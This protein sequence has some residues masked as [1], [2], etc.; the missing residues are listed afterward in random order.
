[1]ASESQAVD[2]EVLL[3]AVLDQ[4]D[5]DTDEAAAIAVALGAHIGDQAR[6]AAAAAAADDDGPDW[7]GRRW[8]YSGR[9][10]R[11]YGRHVRVPEGA[12]EDPWAAAGRA[13]RM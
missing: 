5:A 2:T 10:A 13:D 7:E 11:R 9:M 8:A 1:M 4:A 6:A 3:A 12:P